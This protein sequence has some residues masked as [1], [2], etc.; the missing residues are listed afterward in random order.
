MTELTV[1]GACHH[2]C[3]DTCAWEVTVVDGV[4]TGLRGSADH[5]F[6]HGTLCPKVNR[7]LD[8]VYHPDRLLTPLRRV[9]AKGSGEFEPI[10]WGE[11]IGEIAARMRPL[12]DAGRAESIL[13][14]EFAGTQGEIQMGVMIDRLFDAIGASDIKRELCGVTASR[15]AAEVLGMPFGVEPESLRHARTVVLWGTNTRITNRHLWPFIE[16]ARADGAL[17]IVIDPIRTDTAREAD[18]FVQLKPGS[19]VALVLAIVHVLDREDL[20]DQSWITD[21]TTGWN[22]LRAAAAQWTPARAAQATGID[23]ERIEWLA[24]RLATEQPTGIRALIGAEHR[25]N[26]QEILRSVA[27]LSAVLGSWREVGGGFARSVG[28]WHES[29]LASQARPARRT[30][31]MARLG[32]V[33]ND[34]NVD[35][36]IEMLLV[37]NSNPAN[38]LPDQN[39]VVAGLERD[40]L[41]TVVIEQ[42]MTDTARYADIVLPATTQIEH[43]DLSPA[44]GHFYLAL[45][46]PAIE[47]RGEALPNT[48]IARRLATALELDDPRLHESDEELVRDLLDS[49]HPFLDGITYERLAAEGWARLAVPEGA[50]P[51]IDPLPGIPT[52]PM[53]LGALEHRPGRETTDGDLQLVQRFPLALMSRKQHPKF[54]NANY[55]GFTAHLPSSGQPLLQIHRD[56]AVARG[57]AEGDRARVFNDRGSLT[58]TVEIS[59][60]VQ[61]GLVAMPFGWWHRSTPEGRAVNALTNA[62]VAADDRGSAYFHD[63]LVQVEKVVTN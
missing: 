19:D 45:N 39:R 52:D 48:E 54:L 11:A 26:G 24:H 10:T 57:I 34:P 9:G 8:R 27:M 30:F 13:Q 12:I 50:R 55:G 4:A 35:P 3:P 36:G 18:V 44:W 43:L 1:L 15:G 58:L 41:F 14:F 25:E 51:H 29:A 32:E 21:H 59:D 53:R 28:I 6:T 31:N 16:Q 47:P 2:D 23:A 22:D 20:I 61:P 49:G 62:T 42:F 56:D 46:Q 17:V 40:D 33:L 37:H 63:T 60:V 5:P 38:I 7:F